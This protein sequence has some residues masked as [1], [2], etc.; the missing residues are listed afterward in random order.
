M[1]TKPP[2]RHPLAVAV[3]DIHASLKPPVA[4]SKEKDW[5][6][7]MR[8]YFEQ[9]RDIANGMPIICAGDV[10]DRWNAPAE[11]TNFLIHYMP[12]MYSVAGNHDCPNHQYK[13]LDKSAYWTLVKAG[14]IANLTPGLSA[15]LE[16]PTSIT[17]YGF[18]SGFDVKPCKH[19]HDLM[20]EIAVV[21][22]MIWTENTGY[23]GA[24]DNTRLKAWKDRLRG[25]D[26]AI[27]GDNH[28][29][30][31]AKIHDGATTVYNCGGF[32]RRTVAEE[33]HNPSVGI[34][35]SDGSVERQ[36]LDISSDELDCSSRTKRKEAENEEMDAF[37]DNLKHLN[38]TTISFR[39]AVEHAMDQASNSVKQVILEALEEGEE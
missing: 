16:T 26:I 2:K 38:D 7:T 37:V 19:P 6:A 39:D 14:V 33:E 23:V 29:P 30:F 25:Y 24:K 34:I 5:K 11:L 13:D 8:G 12:S 10:Y 31:M 20:L 35:Y 18:P 15:T 27:F 9:L 17:L 1:Q 21:H 3:A 22:S 36:Y 28:K 4:R 32:V